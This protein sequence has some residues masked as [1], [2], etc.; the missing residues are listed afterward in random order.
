M[1]H[2]L[3]GQKTGLDSKFGRTVEPQID[4]GF[5]TPGS[6]SFGSRMLVLS[7]L[8]DSGPEDNFLDTE[9]ARQ[10]SVPVVLLSSSIPVCALN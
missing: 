4:I 1:L 10:A 3:F 9:V 6:L 8:I 7:A 2:V 5:L